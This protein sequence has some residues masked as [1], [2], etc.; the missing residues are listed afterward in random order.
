MEIQI[1]QMSL[2]V[3]LF[4][5]FFT[6]C[7]C[8]PIVKNLN[9][10]SPVFLFGMAKSKLLLADSVRNNDFRMMKLSRRQAK[11]IAK[12]GFRALYGN[13]ILLKNYPIRSK[14]VNDYYV[15]WG[16]ESYRH[17]YGNSLG[18]VVD[19]RNGRIVYITY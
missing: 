15:I 8:R 2:R 4:I 11:K 13:W 19:R 6:I 7:S 10:L 18:A 1:I 3:F 16:N 5:Q 14:L 12:I 17:A 9:K